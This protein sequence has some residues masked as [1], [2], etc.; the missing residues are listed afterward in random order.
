M[1]AHFFFKE[2]FS[3]SVPYVFKFIIGE[4]HNTVQDGYDFWY[5]L[6]STGK[7]LFMNCN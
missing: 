1:I 5:I 2:L 4:I 6:C 7:N 3:N